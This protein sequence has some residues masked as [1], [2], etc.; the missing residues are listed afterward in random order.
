MGHLIDLINLSNPPYSHSKPIKAKIL[1][2]LQ[3]AKRT[4][5]VK[6]IIARKVFKKLAIYPCV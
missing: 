3:L 5:G 4:K 6:C 1:E 2:T